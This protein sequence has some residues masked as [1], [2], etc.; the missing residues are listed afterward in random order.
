MSSRCADDIKSYIN[1]A[2]SHARKALEYES[3]EMPVEASEQWRA[4]FGDKFPKV[5]SNP[6]KKNESQSI[7]NPIRPWSF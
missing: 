3:S 4:I 1:T 5:Q 6:I 2:L 7:I